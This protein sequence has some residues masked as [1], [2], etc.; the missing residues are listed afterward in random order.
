MPEQQRML[1]RSLGAILPIALATLLSC[2]TPP[3]ERDETTVTRLRYAS[4]YSSL[5]PFSRAD[6]SWIKHVEAASGGRLHI[7]PHWSGSLLSADQSLVELRHGVADLGVITPIYARGGA[8]TLR[9]QAGFYAGALSFETQVAA[10]KC[11]AR[12]FPRFAH[13]LHG[14]EVLAVQGGNLPGIVTRERAVR[15]I[16]DLTGLRLRAPAE[17]LEVLRTLGADP[18]IMPMG[19]VYSAMAKGIL[20]GVVASADALGALHLAE[21]AHHYTRLSIPRG[22]YPARAISERALRRLSPMRQALLRESGTFWERALASELKRALEAGQRHGR[23]QG[24]SFVTLPLRE[25]QRFD[26][27]YEASARRSAGLLAK[28][29]VDGIALYERAQYWVRRL[30]TVDTPNA[31]TAPGRPTETTHCL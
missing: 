24:M 15:S 30:Q 19:E 21:V 28:H 12:E 27:A 7:E 5:H 13:E 25:Q 23:E 26:Q 17:L 2:A 1:R 8:H 14:L 4:P 3:P 18:V 29:G 6:S 9:A 10:Y 11:L 31:N 16:D 20:D 22:G